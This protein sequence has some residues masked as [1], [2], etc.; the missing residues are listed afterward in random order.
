M[1][2]HICI[3]ANIWIYHMDI[4]ILANTGQYRPLVFEAVVLSSQLV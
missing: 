1:H 3:L 2:I 4:A